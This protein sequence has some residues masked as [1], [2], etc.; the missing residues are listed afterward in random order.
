MAGKPPDYMAYLVRLWRED[1]RSPWHA[2]L[3]NPHTGQKQTFAT[4]EDL[5]LFLQT[6]MDSPEDNQ[7]LTASNQLPSTNK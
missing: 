6:S 3:Q 1:G 7:P 2:S 5:W 4:P